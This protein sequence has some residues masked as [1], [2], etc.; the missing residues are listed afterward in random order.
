MVRVRR[1]GRSRRSASGRCPGAVAG[2]ADPDGRT[3]LKDGEAGRACQVRRSA[4]MTDRHK[5]AAC[6]CRFVPVPGRCGFPR[7]GLVF[8]LRSGLLSSPP[9]PEGLM[10]LLAGLLLV[11]VLP[12][13]AHAQLVRGAVRSESDSMAINAAMVRLID[14]AGVTTDSTLTDSLGGFLLSPKEEGRY[15]I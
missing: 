15:I 6:C 9:T 14:H 5:G 2:S 11:I 7:V 12:A 3:S 8:K 4:E 10:R 13:T 1:A